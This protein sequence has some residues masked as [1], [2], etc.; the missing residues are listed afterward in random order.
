MI[1][2][3]QDA[4][5]HA[6]EVAELNKENAKYW[7]KV[8]NTGIFT[9]KNVDHL[10]NTC[11]ECAAEHEQ[12]VAWLTE[13]LERRE[14]DD[15][16]YEGMTVS[17]ALHDLENCVLP[18]VGGKSIRIAIMALKAIC[19]RSKFYKSETEKKTDNLPSCNNCS[20]NGTWNCIKCSGFDGYEKS[21]DK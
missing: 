21:E 13:L 8:K 4:I 11:E 19:E 3:L 10:L 14:A 17:E 18:V 6:K 16:S 1:K 7:N 2:D 15:I 9:D 5:S 12:L 20:H